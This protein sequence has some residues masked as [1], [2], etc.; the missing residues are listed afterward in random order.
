[1]AEAVT[2]ANYG[3]AIGGFEM[4]MRDGELNYKVC[5]PIDEAMLSHSQYRHCMAA[6]LLTIKRYMPAYFQIIFNGVSAEDAI[7][8]CER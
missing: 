2:R 6:S 8:A 3:L 7:E 5:I 1:M 4:D